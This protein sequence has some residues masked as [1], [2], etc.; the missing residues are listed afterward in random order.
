MVRP[1][2]SPNFYSRHN[3][4]QKKRL[5]ISPA[6]SSVLVPATYTSLQDEIRDTILSQLVHK[7][8]F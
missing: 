2:N 6:S 7:Y 1:Q 3:V 8:S 5:R 4:K